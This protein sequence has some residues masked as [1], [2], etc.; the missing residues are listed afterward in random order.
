MQYASKNGYKD[1]V[2]R[3]PDSDIFFILLYHAHNIDL[4]IYLDTGS[5]KHRRV[6]NVTEQAQL[7]GEPYCAAL[8]G[9]YVWTG[10]DATSAF[11]G[12]GKVGP[13]KKLEK[14]P[15]FHKTFEVLGDK[16]ELSLDAQKMLE[17]FV[18]LMYGYP[19]DTNDDSVRKKCS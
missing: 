4:T 13:M 6:I 19:R 16:W 18:C 3:S 12:K 14:N 11:K 8:L 5:G 15:K 17:Q 9:L 1:A 7:L 2:V 10:E